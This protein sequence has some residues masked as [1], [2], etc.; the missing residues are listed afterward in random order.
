[1]RQS[2]AAQAVVR[3]VRWATRFPAALALRAVLLLGVAGLAGNAGA[4]QESATRGYDWLVARAGAIEASATATA[5]QARCETATTLHV[6]GGAS[7]QVDTLLSALAA[8]VEATELLGCMLQLRGILGQASLSSDAEGR[9][10]GQHG[11]SAY[12]GFTVSSLLD[13]AWLLG[14]QLPHLKADDRSA[15]LAWIA[16]SQAADGSFAVN[17]RADLL[18]TA[19]VLRGLHRE[20]PASAE[21]ATVARKAAD[22]LLSKRDPQGHWAADVGVSAVVLEAVY[23][24]TGSVPTVASAVTSWL[25]A[26]QDAD[27]SWA[28]DAYA[29]AVATRA[30]R[31]AAA[32]PLEPTRSGLRVRFVDGRTAL[33]LPGVQV[34]LVPTGPVV[35]SGNDGAVEILDVSPGAYQLTAQREGYAQVSTAATLAAGRLLDLGTV[36]L[37]PPSAADRAVVSGTIRVQGSSAPLPG[38][39]VTLEPGPLSA[40]AGVDGSY[41]I[42]GVVPG[43]VTLSVR[44]PGYLAVAA[45]ASVG[46]GQMLNFSPLLSAEPGG[47]GHTGCRVVGAILDGGTREPV[48]GVSVQISGANSATMETDAA[49][50]YVSPNLVSGVISLVVS[51]A[52]YDSVSVTSPIAC[53]QTRPSILDFSPRLYPSGQTPPNANRSSLTGRILD[54]AT[55]EPIAGAQLTLAAPPESTR[56]GAS[57]ADGAFSFAAIG[58]SIVS[59]QVQA[60]GYEG[61]T[62]QYALPPLQD[63]D[64]GQVRL[65]RPNV[66]QLLPDLKVVEVRRETARTDPQSLSL[67][68]AIAVVV[69]NVGTQ[70]VP[71]GI[72]VTA[73]Q[74]ANGNHRFDALT[75]M[76]LGTAPTPT[77]APG[78]TA[79][80]AIAVQGVLAYRDATIHVMADAAG[81]LAEASEA[82]NTGKTSD[83]ALAQPQAS[84]LAPEQKWHWNASSFQPAHVQVESGLLVG[85]FED[86]DGDGKLGSRDHPRVLFVT[87]SLSNYEGVL[88]VVDGRNGSEIRSIY[89]PGGIPLSGY[90]GFAAA[91]VDGNGV[92]EIFLPTTTGQLV[93]I[94]PTGQLNWVSNAIVGAPGQPYGGGPSVA[95]IDGDGIP[96][97][98]YGRFVLNALTGAPKWIGSGVSAG[99][100]IGYHSF[101]TD[102]LGDGRQHVIVGGSA[103]RPDGQLLWE[104]PALQRGYAA[105]LKLANRT[106]AQIAVVA[107]GA[108]YLLDSDGSIIWGPVNLG[109]VP[110]GA[111][112]I[113]DLDGDGVP[114]IGVAGTFTYRAFRA[115]GS[116]LWSVPVNDG[117]GQTGSTSFDFDGDGTA[118]VVYADQQYV[119]IIN[120]ATG[121]V[122][123]YINHSNGT[124]G[125]QPVVADVDNDGHADFLVASDVYS[126][127]SYVGVRAFQGRGNKWVAARPLWNQYAYSITN[128]NDDLTVPRN[129]AP[130]WSAHNTFRLNK[131][132]EVDPRAIPDLTVGY[133]RVSDGGAAGSTLTVRVGNAGGISV[134]AGARLAVYSADPSQAPLPATVEGTATVSTEIPSGQWRDI[135]IAVSKNLAAL[136][137]LGRI[138]IVGDDDG[139]GKQAL[140][141]F[142]RSNNTVAAE[143][144]LVAVNLVPAVASARPSYTAAEQAI[145]TVSVTNAGSFARE[146]SVRLSI[147][148]ATGAVVDRFTLAT[149]DVPAGMSEAR[150]AVWP[151]AGVSSGDY[152]VQADLLSPAGLPYGTASAAFKVTAEG[153]APATARLSADRASYSAAQSVQ[154]SARVG[155]NAENEALNDLRV[156]TE[157]KTESGQGVFDQ[158]E[159]VVQL[160]ARTQRQ[161]GYALSAA[162]LTPGRYGASTR[163]IDAAGVTLAQASTAFSVVGS[164]QSGVGLAGQLQIQPAQV[165]IGQPVV[166]SLTVTNN[167]ATQLANLPL[168]LRV[169][170]PASGQVVATLTGNLPDLPA[171][172]S[173]PI[174]FQWTSAGMDGQQLVAS[175]TAAV[176]G[177]D[178]ALAQGS[179]RA[180][181]VPQLRAEPQ[182]VVFAPVREG[183]STNQALTLASVGSTAARTLTFTLA[184][185]NAEQFAVPAG[186]CTAAASLPPGATCTLTISYRPQTAGAHA[187]ELLVGYST[188]EPLR[189]RL[190]G[191]ATTAPLAGT[192][193][194][195][196]SEAK[197][198]QTLS[199]AYTVSNPGLV[200]A[201]AALRLSVQRAQGQELANWPVSAVVAGGATF[202]GNQSYTAGPDAEVLT[203]ILSHVQGTTTIVLATQGFTVNPAV[204]PVKVGLAAQIKRDARILMLASCSPSQDSHKSHGEQ[205]AREERDDDDDDKRGR[206]AESCTPQPDVSSCLSGRLRAASELFQSLGVP[207]KIVSTEAAF[208]H[209]MRCGGYNTYWVSGGSAKLD[210]WLVK[211]LRDAV[212]GGDSLVLDGEHDDRNLLLHDVAGVKYRG[213]L[214][215]SNLTATIPEG[216]L[217]TQGSLAT[218]GQPAKFDLVGGRRQ[219]SFSGFYAATPAIVSHTYGNGRSLLFAFD[220][221]G[222]IAAGANAQ[223][224]QVVEATA[225]HTASGSADLTLGDTAAIA[226]SV[227]NQGTRTVNV[228]VQ[229]DLPAGAIHVGAS[230]EPESVDTGKAVWDLILAG[231]A[232]QE[233]TWRVRSTQAGTITFPITVHSVPD[234][235]GTLALQASAQAQ[236]N[237]AAA[238]TLLQ[239]ALPALQAL[240]PPTANG[241]SMKAKA[242]AAAGDALALHNQGKFQEA[243]VQWSASVNAVMAI[244]GID[245]KPARD[246]LSLALEA[247]TDTLCQG[248][249]CLSG[250]ITLPAQVP[251]WS[252]L[253]LSRAAANS[254]PAPA[255]NLGLLLELTNRRT[256][257]QLLEQPDPNVTLGANQTQQR[258]ATWAVQSPAAQSGDW[259][260]ALLTATWQGHQIELARAG[261]QVV[262]SQ[263]AC[264]PGQPLSAS[265]FAPHGAAEGLFAQGGKESSGGSDAWEW[266]IGTGVPQS[267][268]SETDHMEWDSGRTYQWQLQVNSSGQGSFSVK[269]GGRKIAGESFSGHSRLKLGNALRLA[270]RTAG[271]AGNARIAATLTRLDGQSASVNLATDAAGQDKS[272]AVFQPSLANGF[273]AEG[274]V[275]LTFTGKAPPTG[276]RLQMSVQAGTAQC[277]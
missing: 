164:D 87:Y 51:K 229:G 195:E 215:R 196:P 168:H 35:A 139:T 173:R 276:A 242:I 146:T 28:Q 271:D 52:G 20:A 156:V 159:T 199:L 80:V 247:S 144:P 262:P 192:L 126:G 134:P 132:L 17:G 138:W 259:L 154:L 233:L 54:A 251:I 190:H 36:Q 239:A 18:A 82:N 84:D 85:P 240:Q 218:L 204:L 26:R 205:Y 143:L 268:K 102:L 55:G 211:E 68:G 105:V 3:F 103:Y 222:M 147:V 149:L 256:G 257:E 203:A 4:S 232:T 207:H 171:G 157:V 38:A 67:S 39:S 42:S 152:R 14:G 127:G 178:V 79:T 209:E 123:F 250:A 172:Q 182:A 7:P 75:E 162:T 10:I 220:L 166:F 197:A 95:D 113:A 90:A 125:E 148:D 135:T 188:A 15:V 253:S 23:P 266:A 265:R 246:A 65:R 37:L 34:N 224:S 189:V 186:G 245:T 25:V 101:A 255:R 58:V 73:F 212:W 27:G 230:P 133:V 141:D 86:T 5:A 41:V 169:L 99:S 238:S 174:T 200:T 89:R 72:P 208:K 74:D 142:D 151:V 49:G 206:R 227:S 88:R 98:L 45:T 269:D 244:T 158:S 56:T 124:A 217:F 231:G 83:L 44:H 13:T 97:I 40:T 260:D 160:P 249:A 94:S 263:S 136:N 66:Q 77:L 176:N 119:R 57:A 115:D 194:V 202:A 219:A 226:V 117:S 12:P 155:N 122:R 120:G 179:L 236:L 8:D 137:A 110:G 104:I 64:V 180:I 170:D 6:F 198:G 30:I 81:E 63:L 243:I 150:E 235:T 62:I 163:L 248:L 43:T 112:T 109:G 161:F 261:T 46:A 24:Y 184:G 273:S 181:G 274:T 70:Q 16:G 131:R 175:A 116:L 118:D 76:V 1:M 69:A 130:S 91:D 153:G 228:Q 241:R 193:S 165:V 108:V 33:P 92:A 9:R 187:G 213:K 140:P 272:Q 185:A 221:V 121:A 267:G 270:I 216:S 275:K 177:R 167:S 201:T 129:P 258:S 223:V 22:W 48:S 19:I 21:A 234:G 2:Q 71:A 29:T 106:G 100:P 53:D 50:K 214:G 114:D 60:A 277:Q 59:L 145:F 191:E 78:A 225:G 31:M 264:Q 111:P 128:I 32:P 183:A 47:T 107:G 237:V 61:A 93:S 210:H 96:E 11:W 254:C 252:Q